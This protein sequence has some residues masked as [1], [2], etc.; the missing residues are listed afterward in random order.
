M[1]R[2]VVLVDGSYD[3]AWWTVDGGAGSNQGSG[4][5]LEVIAGQFDASATL[6]GGIY[7]LMGSFWAGVSAQVLS[8]YV[9]L[10]VK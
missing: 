8:L 9:P 10:I 6:S 2:A 5:S 7:L 1:L 3:L 4:Y